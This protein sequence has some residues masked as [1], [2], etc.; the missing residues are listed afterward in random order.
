M[1]IYIIAT[2]AF[3]LAIA[4]VA[5]AGFMNIW[6]M[7]FPLI[8][9]YMWLIRKQLTFNQFTVL[10]FFCGIIIDLLSSS[11]LG[12]ST[13]SILVAIAVINL[14]EKRTI[15]HELFTSLI[16]L[17]ASCLVFVGLVY[18]LTSQLSSL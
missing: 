16:S 1:K 2:M 4:Q 13:F 18:Y 6:G 14:L 7:T 15:Y 10:S 17:S 9:V 3:I 8:I 11:V 5:W 12:I